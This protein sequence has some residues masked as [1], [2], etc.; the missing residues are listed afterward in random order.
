M[1]DVNAAVEGQEGAPAVV[2]PVVVPEQ[3][4]L[5][6]ADPKPEPVPEAPKV[7]PGK[8]GEI[9]FEATGNA[10]ADYALTQIGAA[11]I[12]PDHPAVA[13]ALEGDFTLLKH[14]LAA[15]G[16]AG[17]DHLVTMLERAAADAADA[18]EK[19]TAQI[20]SDVVA[21]AGS[22]E[23]WDE[24]MAWGR[25]NA[26]PAEK[27][28]LNELFGNPKTHKI[29]AGYL[30]SAYDRAGG[31]RE[32]LQGVVSADGATATGGRQAVGGPLNRAQFSVEAQKLHA[33]MGD[34]YTNS[35]EYHALGQ[36]LVR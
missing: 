23:Q 6:A 32:A 7:E 20:V 29:A 19:Q 27:E 30:L 5:G 31:A 24:V 26:D 21:M 22:Q 4:N 16:V 12:G 9:K 3:P 28:A 10:Q 34:S 11:G 35:P 33:A 36:R 17:S 25:A 8:A 18:E 15:K 13:A 14:A 2:A 1:S